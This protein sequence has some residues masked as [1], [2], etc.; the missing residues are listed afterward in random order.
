M[1][2]VDDDDVV[3]TDGSPT[4]EDT[5]MV[6]F[7]CVSNCGVIDVHFTRAPSDWRTRGNIE[8]ARTAKKIAARALLTQALLA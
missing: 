8:I 7:L 4:L 2:A 3:R 6:T 1:R 5:T